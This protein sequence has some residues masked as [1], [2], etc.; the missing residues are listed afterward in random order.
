[1]KEQFFFHISH[2]LKP[3]NLLQDAVQELFKDYNKQLTEGVP[4]TDV[5]NE[6]KQRAK[7]IC[8]QHP[9]CKAVNVSFNFW[10]E[11]G[12]Q[13]NIYVQDLIQLNFYKVKK[14]VSDVNV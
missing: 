4:P 7:R 5:Y 1:M 12:A 10:A 14:V 9:K 11:D 13:G 2:T 3:K 6:I 8:N